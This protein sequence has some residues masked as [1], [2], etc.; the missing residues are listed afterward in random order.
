VSGG[1]G[2]IHGTEDAEHR[3]VRRFRRAVRAPIPRR[4]RDPMPTARS[5]SQIFWAPSASC[6][7][8]AQKYGVHWPRHRREPS[9]KCRRR[10]SHRLRRR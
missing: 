4:L 3:I 10:S 5:A 8:V 7:S 1:L 2:A 6:D 9:P